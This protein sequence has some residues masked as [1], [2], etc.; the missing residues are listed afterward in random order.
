M[1]GS[2]AHNRSTNKTEK[3][4]VNQRYIYKTEKEFKPTTT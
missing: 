3:Y 2:A 1:D 4:V